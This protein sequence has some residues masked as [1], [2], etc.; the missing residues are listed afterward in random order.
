MARPQVT[1]NR[2]WRRNLLPGA[3]RFRGGAF[4]CTL[5]IHPIAAHQGGRCVVVHHGLACPCTKTF[6]YYAPV[7]S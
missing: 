4:N 1:R 6:A 3:F 5:C 7:A 2:H